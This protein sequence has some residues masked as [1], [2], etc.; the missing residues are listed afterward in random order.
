[1]LYSALIF[2]LLSSL[3]CVGMCGAISVMLPTDNF[4][5]YK[6]AIQLAVYHSGKLSAYASIG[7]LFG[8]LGKGLYIAGLQQ[9]LS[10]LLGILIIIVAVTPERVLMH[11]NFSKPVYKIIASIKSSLGKQFKNKSYKSLYTIGLLNGFLPCAMVY[12]ALFGAIAMQNEFLGMVYMI[13]FGI[14]TI[15]LLVAVAYAKQFISPSFRN[16]TQKILPYVAVFLGML[17]VMRGLGLGIPYVSP[18][19]MH[20]FVTENPDCTT[21]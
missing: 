20:L 9:Q 7:L 18:A 8:L 14:G 21:P 15:P 4:N 13:L 2:G 1:M 10:I 5:P 19:N 17:F 6:K 3:H 12:M 11:Y 16:S